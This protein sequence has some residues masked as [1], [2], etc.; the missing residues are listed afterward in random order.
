MGRADIGHVEIDDRFWTAA[1]IF[2]LGQEQADSIAIEKSE[3]A[4]GVEVLQAQHLAVPPLG[5]LNVPN[6]TRDL[7]YRSQR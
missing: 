5:F 3:I 6:G 1:G 7:G 4:E 2:P